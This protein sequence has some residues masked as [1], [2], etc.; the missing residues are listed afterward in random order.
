MCASLFFFG[1]RVGDRGSAGWRPVS[2]E[3]LPADAGAEAGPLHAGPAEAA[4]GADED[5][6]QRGHVLHAAHA[7]HLHL[8]VGRGR[9]ADLTFCLTLRNIYLCVCVCV[10]NCLVLLANGGT[11]SNKAEIENRQGNLKVVRSVAV[12]QIL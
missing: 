3:D 10:L 8:Q 6:G 9:G 7:L 1:Q 2:A 5:H 12:K 4:G 11:I